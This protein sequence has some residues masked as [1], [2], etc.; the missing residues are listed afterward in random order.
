VVLFDE[1][2]K[3]HPDVFHILLQVMDDGRL[4]DSYG[5]AIDFKNVILIMTSN[6]GG[7]TIEKQTALGFQRD[8]EASAMERMHENIKQELKRTFNPEFLNRIDEVVMFHPLSLDHIVQIV[9]I[10]IERLNKQLIE[11][12]ITIEVDEEAKHWL[13][14]KGHDPA[15]G[16]RPLKRVIQKQIEDPL[17]EEVVRGHY[18]EG[19]IVEVKRNGDE[20]TFALKKDM[21]ES[22][23]NDRV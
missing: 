17:S 19:G 10:Q 7:R 18:K 14:E 5:R 11:K 21:V 16:A 20:L 6:R 3:A 4:T 9:D 12:G 2:E 15:Y 13:A 8:G 23:L 22:A 1:I